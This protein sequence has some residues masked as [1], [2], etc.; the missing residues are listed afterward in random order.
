MFLSVQRRVYISL[1]KTFVQFFRK[2][3][4]AVLVFNVVQ[5]NFIGLY[6]NSCHIS[7]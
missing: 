7:I 1:A 4:L 5:I 3:D 2:V 6:G